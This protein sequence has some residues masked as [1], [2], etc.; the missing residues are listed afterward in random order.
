M[1]RQLGCSKWP[2]LSGVHGAGCA[3]GGHGER[4]WRG[5]ARCCY[6]RQRGQRACAQQARGGAG[7]QA[8]ARG[9]QGAAREVT[10]GQELGCDIRPGTPS[11]ACIYVRKRY[12]RPSPAYNHLGQEGV[13]VV[14]Q[15]ALHGHDP[16]DAAHQAVRMPA[17]VAPPWGGPSHGPF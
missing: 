7:G 8:G 12:L 2:V 14:P 16:Q 17:R 4:A 3:A 1:P 6:H 15:V 13:R 5:G 9:E 10:Q 11:S